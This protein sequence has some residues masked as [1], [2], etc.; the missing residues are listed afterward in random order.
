M[1]FRV[2]VIS[3]HSKLEFS[4]NYLVFKTVDQV[5]RININEIQTLIIESTAVSITTSLLA[6]LIK[7]KIKIIFCDEKRNPISELVP[8]YGDS[9]S[10]KRI[11]QQINWNQDFKDKIW[12]VII[13]EKIKNQAAVLKSV[14]KDAEEY[15]LNQ[16]SLVE[17]GDITNREGHAA[18]VYFNRIFG[19]NFKRNSD[20][21]KNIFLNYGYSLLLS[22][23]NKSIV[24]KGYLTQLGIHH[25]NEF[26][27]FNLSCD[28]MEPLRP[29]I[30]TRIN[31]MTME[32]F[33]TKL[34]ELLTEQFVIGDQK[35]TLSNAISLYTASIINALNNNDESYVKFIRENE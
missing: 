2:V 16:V 31:V 11:T 3:S 29:F 18:K 32:N 1:G 27:Q 12:K 17:D 34:I 26:N 5:K 9:I 8:Y 14:D 20:D 22:Q 13:R 19:E 28:F 23:F 15:L 25:K 24:S 21:E 33:K 4:L 35:Q 10:Y 6:E 30:D 7:N